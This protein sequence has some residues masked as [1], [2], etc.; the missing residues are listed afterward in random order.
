MPDFS[1]A[2][3]VRRRSGL[4]VVPMLLF[5]LLVM[6]GGMSS[7]IHRSPSG[8]GPTTSAS[9]TSTG[10]AHTTPMAAAVTGA[11]T[12]LLIPGEAHGSSPMRDT[13]MPGPPDMHLGTVCL[14]V[15]RDGAGLGLLVLAAL[16]ALI[17]TLRQASPSARAAKAVHPRTF[18]HSD[19][20]RLRPPP[21]A[22]L[23]VLRL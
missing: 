7:V 19:L 13:S 5:G 16:T 6:H 11:E 23:C 10:R 1:K 20:R 14:G 3:P 2:E 17:L 12:R 15:L 21:C 9:V 8:G 18:R 22:F 4:A